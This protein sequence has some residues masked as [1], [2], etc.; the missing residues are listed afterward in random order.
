MEPLLLLSIINTKLRDYYKNFDDL[1]EDL[2]Y[3]KEE[4]IDKLK[5][6][7]YEYNSNLNQFKKIET[8]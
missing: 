4:I 8:N 5:S 1:C 6:I 3:D 7:G 2:E